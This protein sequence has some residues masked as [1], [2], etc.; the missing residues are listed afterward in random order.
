MKTM[1]VW[2]LS[3]I[4]LAALLAFLAWS[5]RTTRAQNPKTG[6]YI[7]NFVPDPKRGVLLP[8]TRVD[9]FSCS[10]GTYSGAVT[11]TQTVCTALTQ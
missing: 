10:Q 8:G 6:F 11:Y 3:T 1:N 9:G 7:T 4:V 5:G 2:K